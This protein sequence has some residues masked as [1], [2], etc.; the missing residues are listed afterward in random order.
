M[1]PEQFFQKD[2]WTAGVIG[3]GYVGLPLLVTAVKQ[4]LRGI[5]FDVSQ[6]RVDALNA[7]KSHIDDVSDEE[8]EKA[9]RRAGLDYWPRLA[10]REHESW[11]AFLANEPVAS[12][13]GRLWLYTTKSQRPQW[14]ARFQ[15]GDYLL[16]GKETTGVPPEVHEWV[17]QTH[18]EDHRITLPMNPDARSLNL[19]TVVCAAAYEALRQFETSPL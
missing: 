5:G 19:S 4:G 13:R 8:V 12:Q 16:F 3:L 14:E 11:E 17:A 15:E 1:S 2:Q 7:G 6:E 10:P 9:L 18:G